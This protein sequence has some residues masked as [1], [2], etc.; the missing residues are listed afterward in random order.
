MVRKLVIILYVFLFWFILPALLVI[1]SIFL[2]Q[3]WNIYLS[4]SSPIMVLGMII[5]VLSAIMLAMSIHQYIHIGSELPISAFRTIKLIRSGLYCTWRHPIYLF[6]T[7]FFIGVGMI[8]R[9]GTMVFIVLPI[10]V[11]LESFYVSFEEV[12]LISRYGEEYRVYKKFTP[13]VIPSLQNIIRY[14][15][16]WFF[17]LLFQCRII[18]RERFPSQPPFFILSSHRNYFDPFFIGIATSF[19][20]YYI[21]T[22]EV[23]RSSLSRFLFTKLHCIPR[24]R[25]LT[26]TQTTREIINRIDEGGVIMI[27]P[28]GERSWTGTMSPFK[29]Q[30]LKLLK[31]YSSVPIV[32]IRIDGNYHAWPRWRKWFRPSH[33]I[34]TVQKSLTLSQTIPIE[35]ME[36]Q[37]RS[38]IEPQDEQIV[39]SSPSRAKGLSRLIYRCPI[40]SSFKSL[41]E[42]NGVSLLC[43]LCQTT[44]T[45]LPDSRITYMEGNNEIIQSLNTLYE[46]IRIHNKDIKPFKS[47]FNQHQYVALQ[48]EEWIIAE[49][50]VCHYF[51]QEGLRMKR[52]TKSNLLLTNLHLVFA[53]SESQKQIDLESIESCTLESNNKLQLYQE[54]YGKLHQCIFEHESALLWQDY[55]YETIRST[56]GRQ[57]NRT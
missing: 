7:V 35:E 9:S 6:F 29:S 22:F 27:F 39:C 54:R 37:L 30:V 51:V 10:F 12:K 38:L 5:T 42:T 48:V 18:H 13:L 24:K 19:P 31:H 32:P 28:E 11:L 21:T 14:P 40:C 26:D 15:F 44:Y 57:I 36:Q 46:R 4:T 23:F 33:V 47:L 43:R 52:I 1:P 49:S 20:I 3:R 41:D 50:E 16:F 25:Y 8:M 53:R 2:D 45:L 55:I 17:K 34:L 56:Q